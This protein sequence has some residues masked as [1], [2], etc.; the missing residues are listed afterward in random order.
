MSIK[1]F[2]LLFV[3]LFGVTSFTSA[4]TSDNLNNSNR[5]KIKAQAVK[6]HR[7]LTNYTE[8]R[9][10]LMTRVHIQ[11]ENNSFFVRD[12]YCGQII[13]LKSQSDMPSHDIINT[14]H[15]W[16][17]SRFSNRA[18]KTQQKSDLH[19][20]YP[21]NSKANSMRA[22]HVFTEV[23]DAGSIFQGCPESKLGTIEATGSL[24]F[25]P[26]EEHK[27]NVARA[28]FYFSVRYDIEI[29]DHEETILRQWHNSDP[30]DE[31][32]FR[33]NNSIEKIQ[34]NRNP[35]ID[36]PELADQIANF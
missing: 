11:N 14:E 31:T 13:K 18:D 27:G 10:Y 4:E 15:T 28:L 34:G 17:Q 1:S 30:I 22:N 16:P 20:L 23:K 24:G 21:T 19:H 7:P 3:A 25:E 6:G 35:F 33:R 8:A 9:T 26:P 32:E 12:V 2:V 29:P 36:E 5:L